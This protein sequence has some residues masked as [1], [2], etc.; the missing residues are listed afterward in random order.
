MAKLT[1]LQKQVVKLVG[2][3]EKASKP[4]AFVNS[5][6]NYE[7]HL[8]SVGVGYKKMFPK[9]WKNKI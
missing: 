1:D 2:E 3:Y 4:E 6:T 8:L 7:R 5:L 9:T